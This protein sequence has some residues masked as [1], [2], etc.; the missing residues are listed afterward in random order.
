MFN[1]FEYN[2]TGIAILLILVK[3]PPTE[4]LMNIGNV[5][6]YIYVYYQTFASLRSLPIKHF[7]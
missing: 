5:T 1:F 6:A 3:I 4:F 2:C 7:P